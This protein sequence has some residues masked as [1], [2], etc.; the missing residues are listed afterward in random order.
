M[1]PSTSSYS[2]RTP[3]R[4]ATTSARRTRRQ[5]LVNSLLASTRSASSPAS[6]P[7]PSPPRQQAALLVSHPHLDRTQTP[8]APPPVV[9]AVPRHSHKILHRLR[10]RGSVS[11]RLW[12]AVGVRSVN[13]QRLA[14]EMPLASLR[15]LVAEARLADLRDLDR[16]QEVALVSP[17]HWV[18]HPAHSALPVLVNRPSPRSLR[19]L[20]ALA[21]PHNSVRSQTRL[22]PAAPRPLQVPSEGLAERAPTQ[23]PSQPRRPPAVTPSRS[24]RSSQPRPRCPWRHLALRQPRILLHK[25]ASQRQQPRRTHLASRRNLRR[26]IPLLRQHRRA[27]ALPPQPRSPQ[28]CPPEVAI[29]TGQTRP[30]S[31]RLMTVTRG[32]HRPATYCRSRASRSR[33]R[34]WERRERRRSRCR[35]FRTLTA[36]GPRSGSRM[37]LRRTTRTRSPTENTRTER[38]QHMSSS[39]PRAGSPSRVLEVLACPRLRHSGSTAHGTCEGVKDNQQRKRRTVPRLKDLLTLPL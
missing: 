30:G 20:V 19:L 9:P 27:M 23:A 2:R 33:T 11:R 17:R 26:R 6:L 5:A 37:A 29:R 10:H 16:P 32:R 38:R 25:Q 4:T 36:A 1:E 35:A 22:P 8:S 18:S 39:S 31:T 15:P 34:R 7:M 21:S 28:V 24:R 12:V 14:E 3:I 13:R